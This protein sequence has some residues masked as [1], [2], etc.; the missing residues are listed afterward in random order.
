MGTNIPEAAGNH[1]YLFLNLL[2]SLIHAKQL[3]NYSK[4]EEKITI[5]KI[6]FLFLFANKYS[7]LEFFSSSSF[8]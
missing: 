5:I 3:Q 7:F 1:G 2:L 6:L 8:S 4:P